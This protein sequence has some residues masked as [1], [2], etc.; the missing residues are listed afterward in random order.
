MAFGRS[1]LLTVA[2]AAAVGLGVMGI[3]LSPSSAAD[4]GDDSDITKI[5]KKAF[6]GPGRGGPGGGPGGPGGP[7][8]GGGPG[9]APKKP[10][11]LGKAIEGTATEEELKSLLGYTQD[12]AKAKPPK[13]EPADWDDRTSRMVKDVEALSKKDKSGVADLKKASNCKEC[14]T[15]HKED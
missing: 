5:M 12:L 3:K 10:S 8:G 1:K 4:K 6:K 9:G 11:L 7:G 15:K 2:C 14:H 13:G